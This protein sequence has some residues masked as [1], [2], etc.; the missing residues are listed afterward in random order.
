VSAIVDHV[1]KYNTELK[2]QE[3]SISR[4]SLNYLVFQNT[5]N[6]TEKEAKMLSFELYIHFKD[7]IVERE[8]DQAIKDAMNDHENKKNVPLTQNITRVNK[9]KISSNYEIIT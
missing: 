3:F 9:K 1:F 4:N 5:M 7:P 2:F 8:K 6:F